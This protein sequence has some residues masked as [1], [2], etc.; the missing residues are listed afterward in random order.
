MPI[1]PEVETAIKQELFKFD[2]TLQGMGFEPMSAQELQ[3]GYAHLTQVATT[4][5]QPKQ[6]QAA[7]PQGGQGMPQ[8]GQPGMPPTAQQPQ[9]PQPAMNSMA[10]TMNPLASGQMPGQPGGPMPGQSM[11]QPPFQRL[12]FVSMAGGGTVRQPS[13]ALVGEHGPEMALL[14]RGSVILPNQAANQAVS[15]LAAPLPVGQGMPS[16]PPQ[17]QPGM[18]GGLGSHVSAYAQ[19]ADRPAGGMNDYVRQLLLSRLPSQALTRPMTPVAP[20]PPPIPAA[21]SLP[22]QANPQAIQALARRRRGRR[23]EG[24]V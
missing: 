6:G 5:T 9:L 18:M 3:K 14:Q 1:H 4:L 22:T 12:P 10:Q 11:S 19:S 20:T 13:F 24:A 23:F 15:Q 2:R 21:P 17:A 7:Q 8:P 16:L